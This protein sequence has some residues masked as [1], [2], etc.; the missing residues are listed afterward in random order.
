MGALLSILKRLRDAGA[1]GKLSFAKVGPVAAM[2]YFV[3]V[4]ALEVTC[5]LGIEPSCTWAPLAR[6]VGPLIGLQ[7]PD[8]PIAEIAAALVGAWGVAR[9]LGGLWQA[10]QKERVITDVIKPLPD[11]SRDVES[12]LR[13]VAQADAGLAFYPAARWTLDVLAA[14]SK[15]DVSPLAY[16]AYVRTNKRIIRAGAI[17]RHAAP[18]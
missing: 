4:G 12:E 9:Y 2:A 10:A 6:Q 15:M 7:M 16:V 8:L 13:H 5:K 17:P 3:G 11:G 1:L 14:C 18:A